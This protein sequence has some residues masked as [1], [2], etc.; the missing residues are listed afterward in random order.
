MKTITYK[1]NKKVQQ[2]H[3]IFEDVEEFTMFYGGNPPKLVEDWKL[4]QKGDWV[5]ADDG[6]ICQVLYRKNELPHPGDAVKGKYKYHNGYLR[7]VVMT[8][9]INENPNTKLDCDPNKHKNRY[10]FGNAQVTDQRSRIIGRKN[11]TKSERVFIFNILHRGLNLEDAYTGA[12]KTNISTGTALLKKALLLVK[13]ERIVSEIKKEV[14]DAAK[15]LGI[16]HTSVLTRMK[17][18]SDSITIDPRVAL[19]ATKM[20]GKSIQTFEPKQVNK[21]RTIGGYGEVVE[22]LTSNDA[23]MVNDAIGAGVDTKQIK[24]E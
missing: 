2:S 3:N 4:G 19:E 18:F 17:E 23:D 6:K 16:T 22:T 14:A 20:L 7:T 21:Q 12:Y 24:S 10:Q 1:D 5:L 11:L 15:T 8:T 9:V 13:Q